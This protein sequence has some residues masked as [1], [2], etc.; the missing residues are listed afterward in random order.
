MIFKGDNVI[1]PLKHNSALNTDFGF[2][3]EPY[4]VGIRTDRTGAFGSKF[5]K[6]STF[7]GNWM[8]TYHNY[9]VDS[10]HNTATNTMDCRL[11]TL[12]GAPQSD[13]GY[14][15][16]YYHSFLQDPYTTGHADSCTAFSGLLAQDTSGNPY[17]LET[18]NMF[19]ENVRNVYHDAQGAYTGEYV[20][21][22][23]LK[24]IDYTLQITHAIA[25]AII[26]I[27]ESVTPANWFKFGYVFLKYPAS[28][29]FDPNPEGF[30]GVIDPQPK[31]YPCQHTGFPFTMK[32]IA[33][34]GT[35]SVFALTGSISTCPHNLSVNAISQPFISLGWV[36]NPETGT[37]Y[38]A[39]YP[40]GYI[41]GIGAEY[42]G[43]Y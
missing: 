1:I 21:A 32:K 15:L 9:F 14:D 16:K 37:S 22:Y 33:T 34:Y 31:G 12:G 38:Y 17:K 30:I 19:L 43:S 4:T 2:N 18:R 6:T 35:F 28:A 36:T 10:I 11:P 41:L 13:S 29:G 26:L 23:W 39:G 24:R 5:P 8:G 3:W 40:C 20:K 25:Y 27:E 7:N 42:Y